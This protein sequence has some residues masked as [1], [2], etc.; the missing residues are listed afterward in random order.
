MN[1]KLEY[2]DSYIDTNDLLNELNSRKTNYIILGH[3]NVSFKKHKKKLSLDYWNR[4]HAKQSNTKQVTQSFINKLVETNLF[5]VKK[6]ICPESGRS[7][8]ALFIKDQSHE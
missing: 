8:K 5:E 1:V 7:C 3:Q 4:T 2:E 6:G